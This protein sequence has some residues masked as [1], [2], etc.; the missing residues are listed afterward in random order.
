MRRSRF[1]PGPASSFALRLRRSACP[2]TALD[3][4]PAPSCR[5][6]APSRRQATR[7]PR[8]YPCGEGRLVWAMAGRDAVLVRSPYERS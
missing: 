6:R 5:C 4:R 7:C 8:K 1:E 2:G 3:L